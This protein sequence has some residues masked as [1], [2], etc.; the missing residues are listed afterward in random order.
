MHDLVKK[1]S[2][3]NAYF[4]SLHNKIKNAMERKSGH[5]LPF[6]SFK[7]SY[8]PLWIWYFIKQVTLVEIITF[9]FVFQIGLASIF[10][11]VPP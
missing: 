4:L 1:M 10:F 8:K 7:N 2:L 3:H 11:F 9:L 6:Y 5:K